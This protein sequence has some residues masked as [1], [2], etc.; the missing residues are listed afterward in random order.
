MVIQKLLNLGF[1]FFDIDDFLITQLH[2]SPQLAELLPV[3]LE[4][5]NF[6]VAEHVEK[7]VG[8][9]R[10]VQG[11]PES[12]QPRIKFLPPSL[13]PEKLFELFHVLLVANGL[14]QIPELVMKLRQLPDF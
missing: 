11:P 13:I 10:D 7:L 4:R 14:E 1:K 2:G 3:L 8:R 5:L 9:H 6:F 12:S